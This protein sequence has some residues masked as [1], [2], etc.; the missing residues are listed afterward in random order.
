[1]ALQTLAAAVALAACLVVFASSG[2]L[3]PF[4]VTTLVSTGKVLLW[5]TRVL[6]SHRYH[7]ETLV[8]NGPPLTLDASEH[9]LA[10][11]ICKGGDADHVSMQ[12]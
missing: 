3:P 6:L 4:F 7:C 5:N 1:M 2:G 10:G 11:T 9:K 12:V 8:H